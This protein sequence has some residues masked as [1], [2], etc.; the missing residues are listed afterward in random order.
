MNTCTCCVCVCVCCSEWQTINSA[1]R[2]KT[3]RRNADLRAEHALLSAE[4][5]HV[6]K[7]LREFVAN[8]RHFLQVSYR[9]ADSPP[10]LT[11]IL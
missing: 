5:T 10:S 7:K 9:I 3:Q 11:F 1:E 4:K 8:I 2:A 6:K